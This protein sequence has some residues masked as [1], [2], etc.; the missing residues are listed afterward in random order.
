MHQAPG[1]LGLQGLMPLELF[2]LSSFVSDGCLY[3]A[4]LCTRL[5][6][7][8]PTWVKPSLCL[9]FLVFKV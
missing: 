2:F 6:A 9:G 5:S 1:E 7:G 8:I 4:S 3:S